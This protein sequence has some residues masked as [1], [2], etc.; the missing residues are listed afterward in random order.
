MFT[1]EEMTVYQFGCQ[2]LPEANVG[3]ID[4]ALNQGM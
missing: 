3:D 1:W 2:K 4:H